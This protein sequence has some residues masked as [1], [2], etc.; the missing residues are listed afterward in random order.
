MSDTTIAR[1]PQQPTPHRENNPEAANQARQRIAALRSPYLNHAAPAKEDL[2]GAVNPVS[3]AAQLTPNI[4]QAPALP[5]DDQPNVGQAPPASSELPPT[6]R[7]RK[8][9][10]PSQYMPLITGV[11]TFAVLA[12]LFKA[13][14]FL[15]QL[16]YFTHAQS[17]A[18]AAPASPEDQAVLVSADPVISIPKININAPVVYAASN[19]ES[20]I[21][22]DLQSG[23]VHYADTALPGQPGNS[24]IF[25]H[26]SNDWWEPGNFKFV[27]VL[28]DKLQVGDA[29]T[30]NYNSRQYVYQVTGTKVVLPTDLSVLAQ[31]AEPT[32]TLITCTPP[33]TSWKRLVVTAKQINVGATAVEPAAAPNTTT[34]ASPALL[35][36]N[37]PGLTQKIGNFWESVVR[38]ISGQSTTE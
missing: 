17:A 20:S 25:G 35:P 31:T 10:L 13:P 28:L 9:R 26:S 19:L 4:A 14:I 21:Q 22:K 30:V 1:F 27:F 6:A 7:Q 12:L 38:T 29:Y 16:N 8:R 34:G 2:V 33:G 37:N 15:S 11:V 36:G 5:V 32:M 3:P 18:P 23:V 24:V